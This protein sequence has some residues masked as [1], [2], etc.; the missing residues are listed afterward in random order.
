MQPLKNYKVVEP[1]AGAGGIALG[2]EQAGL[3]SVLLNE[4]D[5]YAWARFKG[6]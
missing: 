1:F 5:R 2:F 3:K 4:I 6:G